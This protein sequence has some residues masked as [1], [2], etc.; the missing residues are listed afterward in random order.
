ML[1]KASVFR[2]RPEFKD[3][4]KELHD[5][6]W[7]ELKKEIKNAGIENYSIFFR[8]DG[9]LFSYLESNLDN[10]EYE[11]NMAVYWKKDIV[12]KWAEIMSK[13]IIKEDNSR[14]DPEAEDL[15]EVFHLD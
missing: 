11:Q 8:K 15:Q 2:I 1:R 7:P 4:Y 6:I 3:E 14:A 12:K 13:Y 10:E 9:T 5:Q